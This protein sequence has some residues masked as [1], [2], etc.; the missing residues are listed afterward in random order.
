MELDVK[1]DASFLLE[2][3]CSGAWLEF[4]L[5]AWDCSS[6]APTWEK[7]AAPKKHRASESPMTLKPFLQAL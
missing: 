3:A 1:S 2:H 4:T 7:L 5:T 6:K